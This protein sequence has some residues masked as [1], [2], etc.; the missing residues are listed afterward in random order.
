[1]TPRPPRTLPIRRWLA[2]ALVVAFVV[3]AA[4]TASVAITFIWGPTRNDITPAERLRA[5]AAQWGDPAWQSATAA[6]LA[7]DKVDFVLVEDGREVYRSVP[8]PLA[9]ANVNTSGADQHG[10]P[11]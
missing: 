8:D 7:R 5:D 11:W 6:E 3:P 10:P 2:L 9:T 1:M 4:V